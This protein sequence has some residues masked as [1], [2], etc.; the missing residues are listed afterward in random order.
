MCRKLEQCLRSHELCTDQVAKISKIMSENELVSVISQFSTKYNQSW[1][2]KEN[3]FLVEQS[4][5]VLG[6]NES[7]KGETFM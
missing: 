5:T 3:L 6:N 1:F 7:G 2:F 4:D